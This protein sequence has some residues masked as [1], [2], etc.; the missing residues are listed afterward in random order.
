VPRSRKLMLSVAL[1]IVVVVVIIGVA[2]FTGLIIIP[3]ATQLIVSPSSFVVESGGSIMFS[4][5]LQS[6]TFMLSGKPITWSASEGSLDRTIGETVVYTAPIVTENTTVTITASFAGDRSYYGSSAAIKGVVIPRK[7]A[8]TSLTI[9]P[10]KF[11]LESGQKITLTAIPSPSSIPSEKIMWSLEG[12]G[13]LSPT[14]GLTVTYLAPEVKETISVKITAV[15]LGTA[16]YS[17]STATCNGI[18]KP[19]GAIIRKTT[20][21]TVSPPTFILKPGEKVVLNAILKDAEGKVLTDKPITWSLKGPGE[22]SSKVGSTVTY[23]APGEITETVDVEILVAFEGDDQYLGSTATSEGKVRLPIAITLKDEYVLKFDRATFND[24]KIEGPLTV[25]GI[26]V[27]KLTAGLADVSR[28]NLSRIGLLADK[29]L[30]NGLEIYAISVKGFSPELGMELDIV[31]GEPTSI[32]PYNSFTLENA[33]I[34]FIRM[35]S[36]KVE[37]TKLEMKSEYIGGDEPYKPFIL[38]MLEATMEKGYFLDSP[39]SYGELVDKVIEIRVGRGSMVGFK[40]IVPT[41]YRLD[42]EKNSYYYTE[43]WIISVNNP[44]A[45]NATFYCIYAKSLATKSPEIVLEW[46][47][48]D[49]TP[50]MYG[51]ESG[52]EAHVFE[53]TVHVVYL[54]SDKFSADSWEIYIK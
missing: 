27:V 51:F 28:F 44:V 43:K 38:Y 53:T 33:E 2:L 37:I 23:M 19:K 15:F 36:S 41:D 10:L 50:P 16:G 22:L 47:G 8:S 5:R 9:N 30:M 29:A 52:M 49:P 3:R 11:E 40:F 18:V 20:I 26:N 24:F 46:T 39:R 1:T 17:S 35:I 13:E 4:A 54:K 32:G 42:R 25:G 7:A 31:G 48:E 34:I 21:L 12:P 6:D 14:T 45:D